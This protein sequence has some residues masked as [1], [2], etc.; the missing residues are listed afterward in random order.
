MS[1]KISGEKNIRNYK[2]LFRQNSLKYWNFIV[3]NW[4]V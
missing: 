1:Y 3:K 2:K 4:I